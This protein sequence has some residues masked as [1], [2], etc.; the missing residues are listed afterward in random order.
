[1]KRLLLALFAALCLTACSNS[2]KADKILVI[3][4]SQ[5]NTTKTV[6]QEIQKQLGCDIAEIECVEPYTGDFGAVIGRWQQE[7]KDGKTAE[8][9]PLSKNV[10]D[11]DVIF[12]G[13]PIWGGT[14]ASPVATFLKNTDFQGKKVV[15]FCTFGSGGLNTSTD[16]LKKNAKNANIVEGYG[17]RQ[18]RIAKVSGEV[19]QFLIKAGFKEG[20]VEQLPEFSAQKE[21]TESEMNIFNQA[22]SDY[23]MPLGTPSTVGSRQIKGGTEYL[24]TVEGQMGK[25]QIYVIALD[26]AKPEFTQ[27][28]R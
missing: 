12:L 26:G 22:C 25:S 23:Q 4:Y 28:V 27:V 7:Q 24:Y 6:A 1:M 2:K 19:E 21:V 13:Y 5:S 20:T 10:A 3:Y 17:I 9:K 18:A 15:P 14:Y 16:A 8:I 11:Y